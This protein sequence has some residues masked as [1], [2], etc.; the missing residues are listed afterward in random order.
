MEVINL[1]FTNV[2]G[3]LLKKTNEPEENIPRIN[4][5]ITGDKKD[6]D[7]FLDYILERY[8]EV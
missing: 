1:G 5:S 7:D 4:F 8:I 3:Q 2:R 6:I